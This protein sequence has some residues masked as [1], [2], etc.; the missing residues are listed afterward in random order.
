MHE[1]HEHDRHREEVEVGDFR[2]FSERHRLAE[3]GIRPPVMTGDSLWRQPCHAV[4]PE[5]RKGKAG[6][7]QEEKEGIDQADVPVSVAETEAGVEVAHG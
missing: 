6:Q 1:N 5:K 2:Q 3:G 4:G 7:H